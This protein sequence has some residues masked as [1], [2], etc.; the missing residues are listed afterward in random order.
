MRKS[1]I[2]AAIGLFAAGG[3]SAAQL[4]QSADFQVRAQVNASCRISATDI[5]FTNGGTEA[6]DPI[7][8]AAL[9][10]NGSVDVR[11]NTGAVVKVRLDDGDHGTGTAADPNR[12]MATA[13]GDL[14]GYEIFSD[15]GYATE[16]GAA[17]AN[18]VGYTSTSAATT[19]S[20]VTYGRIPASQDVPPGDYTDMVTATITL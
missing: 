8:G 18:A 19:Q 13:G 9:T 7:E 10:A 5:D 16:W 6:Y 14:L 20:L 2:V 11:C 3:A 15:S 17:D 4:P 1:L 12:F